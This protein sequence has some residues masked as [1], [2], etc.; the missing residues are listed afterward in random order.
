VQELG[1]Q[2]ALISGGASLTPAMDDFF[3]AARVPVL[4]G[5]GMTEMSP[6]ITCRKLD[7]DDA[8]ANVRGT[9]GITIPG[10]ETRCGRIGGH[11]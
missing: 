4:N 2:T 8:E 3:E 7:L 10:T 11:A 9:V 6:V 5:W 1:V